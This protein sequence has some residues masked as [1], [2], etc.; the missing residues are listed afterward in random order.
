VADIAQ[1]NVE[2]VGGVPARAAR[3]VSTVLDDC[4]ALAK[5]GTQSA[6][7]RTETIAAAV[8]K[9]EEMKILATLAG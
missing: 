9:V 2:S 6:F 1:D 5:K 3:H 7:D 8:T 4:A